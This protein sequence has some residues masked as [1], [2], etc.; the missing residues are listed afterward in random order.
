MH[1]GYLAANKC[2]VTLAPLD[3]EI[4][5]DHLSE[6]EEAK[7]ADAD[8][9]DLGLSLAAWFTLDLKL[10]AS[11]R[12]ADNPF[13]QAEIAEDLRGAASEFVVVRGLQK[14]LGLTDS[15][16]R[17]ASDAREDAL[18]PRWRFWLTQPVED[19][20]KPD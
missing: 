11:R 8:P 10:Q 20:A 5:I 9:F 16:V 2:E 13:A 14:K 17:G 12:M 4:C 18:A 1:R 7:I 19:L 15:Q 3:Y 6:A